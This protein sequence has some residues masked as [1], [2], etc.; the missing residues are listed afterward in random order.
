M[1]K[2][3]LIALLLLVGLSACRSLTSVTYIKRGESFVLGDNPHGQYS[4]VARNQDAAPVEVFRAGAD[5]ARVSLGTLTTG[6]SKQ[7]DVP[8]NTTVILKNLGDEQAAVAIKITGDTG[9]GMG[10]KPNP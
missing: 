1:K 10:Y 2:P 6:K 9:L 4:I 7:L 8:A 5:G 3:F